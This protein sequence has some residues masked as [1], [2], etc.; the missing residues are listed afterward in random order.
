MDWWFS[1]VG[2]IEKTVIQ[3]VDGSR[4]I[5]RASSGISPVKDFRNVTISST[6]D[7]SRSFPS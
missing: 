2:K 1:I 7:L 3:F 5:F 6:R 4:G